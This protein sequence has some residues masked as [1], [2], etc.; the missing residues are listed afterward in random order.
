MRKVT[1]L[2]KA[3]AKALRLSE[4]GKQF[5]FHISWPK[6]FRFCLFQKA[7]V[8][9]YQQSILFKYKLMTSC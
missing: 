5:Y 3:E 6:S 9:A 1:T 4:L 8:R 2:I 7:Q